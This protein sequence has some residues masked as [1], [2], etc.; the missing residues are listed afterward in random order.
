ME[1][2]VRQEVRV[3]FAAIDP[4][5]E[6]NAI[7]P[8]ETRIGGRDMIQWGTRNIYPYFLYSLYN[9]VPTLGSVIEGTVNFVAGD[10]VNL[11]P[12]GGFAD[13]IVNN[14]GDTASDIVRELARDYLIYGGFALQVIRNRK[15]DPAEI[16]WIDMR[17]L[18]SNKENTVF[19]Y[20]E[21]WDKP[22]Y[23][24]TLLYPAFVAGLEWSSMDEQARGTHASSILYVKESRRQT[25]PVPVYVQAIKSCDIER[26]ID[27]YHL[28]AI[29]NGFSDGMIINFNNGI[30][31][32]EIKREIEKNINEK[33]GGHQNAGRIMMCFNPDIKNRTDLVMPQT[34][35]YGEKYN[36][37]AA[38][39]RQQIFTAFRANPNLFGIPTEGNGF[40][41]EQYEESFNLYNRTQVKPVQDR[42]S[43]AFAR[44]FGN[45]DAL[46][47]TPFSLQLSK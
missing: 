45:P 22:G 41:N 18:R 38:R 30:P 43:G 6:V 20:N 37:L 24:K 4:Y 39:S 8:T 36:T 33:F 40:A 9:S 14:M 5:I 16:Y 7:L 29:K 1:N 34:R 17:Y 15:G 44:I 19:Y 42:I 12:F 2:K 32:D 27:D 46:D 10:A 25:Y 3:S 47:I 31:S 35:D 21:K 13:S 28:N 26:C 23:R 11:V